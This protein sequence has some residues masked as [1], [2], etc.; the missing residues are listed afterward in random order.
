MPWL[1]LAAREVV[2]ESTGFSPNDLVFGHK[3]CGLLAV[4]Q[5]SVK[6]SD[7][8]KNLLSCV[9]GFRQRLKQARQLASDK[10]E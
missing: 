6:S 2:E 8:P 3:V 10:L 7:S 1:L 9:D 5:S 4:L